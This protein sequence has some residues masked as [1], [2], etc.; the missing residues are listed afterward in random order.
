MAHSASPGAHGAEVCVLP[1]APALARRAADLFVTEARAAIDARGRFAVALSG[2]STPRA[3]YALLATDAALHD[4]IAWDRVY[5][6]WGDER[7]VPPEHEQSNYRMVREALLDRVRIPPENVHRI[8]GEISD[9]DAAAHA[10]QA[11]LRAFFGLAGSDLP[12]LDLV[13]L[14]LGADAHTASLFP[15]AARTLERHDL[16]VA[17]WVESAKA[18]RVSLTAPVLNAA[19]TIAFVV[20]GADKARAV[21]QVLD[22]VRDPLRYPAQLIEPA[23]G[24]LVW[25]LDRA[26][27]SLLPPRA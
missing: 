7:H 23:H 11:E 4:A 14:G 21:Q 9:A 24:R 17:H 3:L 26:A 18:Y 10:Y 25:L 16:V 8:A 15:G 27:A 13:L 5:L 12:R 2:G 20:G 6:F 22:G 1:D 19:R